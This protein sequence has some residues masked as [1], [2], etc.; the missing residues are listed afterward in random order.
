MQRHLPLIPRLTGQNILRQLR[1]LEQS[2]PIDLL[3]P[4]L[5]GTNT[6]RGMTH[7]LRRVGKRQKLRLPR[8]TLRLRHRAPRRKLAL[9][10][11][12][13]QNRRIPH[14]RRQRLI[15]RHIRP[16]RR[17]QQPNRVRH[18]RLRKHRKHIR[19]LHRAARIHHQHIISNPRNHTHVVRN[20]DRGRPGL[21]LRHLNHIQNLRL[22]RHIQRRGRLV[23]N[24][25]PRIIRNRNSDHHPLP[26]T[27]G[28]LV[29]KRSD[30]LLR[31]R[32]PHQIQQ[33]HSLLLRLLLRHLLVR[34]NR[35]NQLRPN[36]KH[37]GERRQR[38]LENHANPL[39]PN[40]R[41]LLIGFA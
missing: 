11:Q 26:H 22:N 32:N 19:L 18:P 37:R 6:C 16:R 14:N 3:I 25:H 33:L 40:L 2:L 5:T 31:L 23:R 17:T 39:P 30:P 20:H 10:L 41:H 1:H 4:N 38:V 13:H 15:T 28:K 35:L 8:Q 12:I 9:I 29:R 7:P 21:P 34:H 27:T 36:I 24:Q